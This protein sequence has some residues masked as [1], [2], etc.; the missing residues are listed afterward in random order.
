MSLGY[1]H[2]L[3]L[4]S[5]CTGESLASRSVID[6]SNVLSDRV[7]LQELV[8]D[9]FQ[10]QQVDQVLALHVESTITLNS[11]SGLATHNFSTAIAGA[12]AGAKGLGMEDDRGRKW[13]HE[14]KW[15]VL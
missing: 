11:D 10:T 8:C 5:R 12:I 2:R 6:F 7:A 1:V 13:I 15:L 4:P 14:L 3:G 9:L